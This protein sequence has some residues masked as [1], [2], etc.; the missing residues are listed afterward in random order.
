M[1]K[2]PTKNLTKTQRVELHQVLQRRFENNN[3]RHPN[4]SWTTVVNKLSAQPAVL[5]SVW[6]MEETG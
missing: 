4:I 3:K 2:L 6:Q 5:W 1:M